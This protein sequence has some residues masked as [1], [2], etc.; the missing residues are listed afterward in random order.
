MA[1][2]L[3]SLIP[4]SVIS[5]LLIFLLAKACVSFVQWGFWNAIWTVPD[6][7]T[8]ACR[9]IRGLGACWAV[10][11]EKYRFILFGTCPFDQQWR[12]ALATLTFVALFFVSSRRS[13]WRKE[14]ILVWVVALVLIGNAGG[15][16]GPTHWQYDVVPP[17][18]IS[19][20]VS[21]GF[22]GFQAGYNFQIASFVLGVEG[23]YEFAN[24]NAT[25]LCPNPFFICHS[26]VQGI[27]DIA[28]RIGYAWDRVLFYAKAA[29]PGHSTGMSRSPPPTPLPEPRHAPDGS[30]A[31]AVE[32]AYDPCWS[33]KAEYNYLD[34]G[35]KT[36]TR[37][38]ANGS[39]AASLDVSQKLNIAKVGLNYKF[40]GPLVAKY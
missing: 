29:R 19:H 16:W 20:Q 4:S 23:D 33:V 21:G 40:G 15:A 35:T 5:L 7:Q 3:F 28:G 11:R 26:K 9:A 32:Y 39:L 12:S 18:S 1:A 25:S 38:N 36:V 24:I 27:A 8:G 10:I 22:G 30:A 34:F 13:F 17:A 31:S 6:N 37:Q 2:N 14:L